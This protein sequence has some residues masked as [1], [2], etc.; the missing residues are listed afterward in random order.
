MLSQRTEPGWWRTAHKVFRGADCRGVERAG[1]GRVVA[2]LA[3][4]G[5]AVVLP[6]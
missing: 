5:A 3:P 4:P 1:Q 6:E 2:L